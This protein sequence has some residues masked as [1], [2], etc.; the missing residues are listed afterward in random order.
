MPLYGGGFNP[1]DAI[2]L[3]W[4]YL[5]MRENV[6]IANVAAK[7]GIPRFVPMVLAHPYLVMWRACYPGDPTGDNPVFI[8]LKSPHP[9]L[10]KVLSNVIRNLQ[11][12]VSIDKMVW[13]YLFRH[14]PC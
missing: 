14:S 13:P 3:N 2:D 8:S 9:R 6:T 5:E 11:Q 7:T 1:G 4:G 10:R 12:D